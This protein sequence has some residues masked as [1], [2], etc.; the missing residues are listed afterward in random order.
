M[1]TDREVLLAAQARAR[2]VLTHSA[3][4]AADLLARSNKGAADDLIKEQQLAQQLLLEE[5]DQAA[6][7][8]EADDRRAGKGLSKAE[9][10]DHQER[11]RLAAAAL[12]LAHERTA[13]ELAK[14]EKVLAAK[15]GE[16][17]A[18]AAVDILMDGHREAAGILLEARMNITDRR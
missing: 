6:H 13:A 9:R 10:V 17:A 14:V 16:A 11:H 18:A 15:V 3:N 7:A 2:Q 5:M 1:S 4:C 12:R 8:Q